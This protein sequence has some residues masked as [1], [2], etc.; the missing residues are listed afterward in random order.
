MVKLKRMVEPKVA[1]FFG[2]LAPVWALASIS[3]SIALSPWFSWEDN[4]LSDLGVTSVSLI[5]NLGLIISGIFSS[6]F[7]ISLVMINRNKLLG[8]IGSIT[9]LLS[10]LSL[11][12]IGLFPENFGL[13]HFY[14]S[15]AFFSLLILSSIIFGVHFTLNLS[16]KY[17]GIFTL[18]VGIISLIGWIIWATV[19]PSGVAIPEIINTILASF[20][21]LMLSIR[22]LKKDS[23]KS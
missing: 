18:S 22:M 11:I 7:I 1:A 9:L 17:V 23:F 13:V 4:A 10:S 6:L 16:N 19:R 8:F 15:L 20:W 2:I 21:I 12:G 3:I 14:F 5:F